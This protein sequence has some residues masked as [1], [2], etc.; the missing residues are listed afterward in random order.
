[1]LVFNES[2]E[3]IYYTMVYYHSSSIWMPKP[4]IYPHIKTSSLN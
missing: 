4:Q 1:M 2:L 3:S